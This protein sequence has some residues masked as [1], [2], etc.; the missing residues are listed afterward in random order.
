L[1]EEREAVH[2]VDSV[3][4]ILLA[5]TVFQSN[6]IINLL[7]QPNSLR[8]VIALFFLASFLVFSVF[9]GLVG[10]LK[11]SWPWKLFAWQITLFLFLIVYL[12]P[13]LTFLDVVTDEK[14]G[15]RIYGISFGF[16]FLSSSLF[17]R[18]LVASAYERRLA[19][20]PLKGTQMVDLKEWSMTVFVLGLIV[21]AIF[22][23]CALLF[24]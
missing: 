21:S 24:L 13:L 17:T 8:D 2:H 11:Q 23:V 15:L 19:L 12:M 3:F 14:L 18:Y 4:G 16:L 20:L 22:L 5:I 7:R 9:A 10:I 1:S 6:F